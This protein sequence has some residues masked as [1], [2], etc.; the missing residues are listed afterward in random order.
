MYTLVLQRND[1]ACWHEVIINLCKTVHGYSVLTD[2]V[3]S[4]ELITLRQLSKGAGKL[5]DAVLARGSG[6]RLVGGTKAAGLR[7][8]EVRVSFL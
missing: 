3:N 1:G 7:D 5:D 2:T 6:S 8:V 4:L